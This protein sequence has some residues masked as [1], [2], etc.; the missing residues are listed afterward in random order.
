MTSRTKIILGLFAAAAAGAAFGVL[1]APEKGSEL[2]KR[3][4]AKAGSVVDDLSELLALG[5]EKV[6]EAY[7]DAA[8]EAEDLKDTVRE[9]ASKAKRNQHS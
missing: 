3:I 4:K 1:F 8:E 9:T 6:Q 2:R 7:A 5:K